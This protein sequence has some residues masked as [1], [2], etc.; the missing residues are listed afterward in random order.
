[1]R[2]EEKEIMEREQCAAGDLVRADKVRDVGALIF[3]A[4]YAFAQHVDWALI[5]QQCRLV[6]IHAAFM[7]RSRPAT[8]AHAAPLIDERDPAARVVRRHGTIECVHPAANNE[9]YIFGMT[10]AEQVPRLL[11]IEQRDHPAQYFL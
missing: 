7:R 1:M 11:L 9:L 4:D 6:E 2:I 8:P 5:L 3:L 10:N